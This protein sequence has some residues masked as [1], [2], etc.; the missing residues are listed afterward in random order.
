MIK[1]TLQFTCDML[2]QYLANTYGLDEKKAVLN[3]IIDADGTL[4]QVNQNKVVISL[5]NVEKETAKPFYV[6]QAKLPN[7]NFAD[8]N[9]AERYNLDL[10]VTSNFDD[11]QE[12]LLFLNAVIAFFQVNNA[13]DAS[14]S[15]AFP[16][17]LVKLEYDIEKISYHQMHS[18]WSAMGAKYQPSVIYKMRLITIQGNQPAGFT[19]A[20]LQTS[21]AAE[22]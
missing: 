10:L 18:L 11:Y 5:I 21:N 13:L 2:S 16:A 15:S 20:V 7:G 9:P 19:D 4:P 22:A 8:V 3:N 6:R 14:S 1:K 12:T 17:G